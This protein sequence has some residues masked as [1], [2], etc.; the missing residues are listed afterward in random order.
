MIRF[1]RIIRDLFGFSRAQINA[2]VVLLPLMIIILFSQPLVRALYPARSVQHDYSSTL[3]SLVALLEKDSIPVNPT[4]KVSR[5][6]FDFNPNDVTVEAMDSLGFPRNLATRIAH[7]RQK[8]GEFRVKHDLLKIYGVDTT[9]YE[10]LYSYIQLPEKITVSQSPRIR[11]PVTP[12]KPTV[13]FDLNLADT[14]QLKKIKG[15]GEKLSVRILRYRESLG[16]FTG[17]SQLLEIYGLDSTVVKT[18]IKSS[19]IDTE[20][21][22]RRMNINKGNERDLSAH[23]YISVSAARAIV[24]Y[25]F[26]HGDFTAVDDL[27]K[28]PVLDEKTIQ[29]ITPYLEFN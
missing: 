23:P 20:F 22:V 19:F 7:Y 17:A 21:Q 3:D 8:G 2:F 1:R 18:L 13:R 26:Q 5:H 28:I 12:E 6:Y 4:K 9:F 24:S 29:K 10:S 25:R 27:R 15:I 11:Y 16:G 14:A